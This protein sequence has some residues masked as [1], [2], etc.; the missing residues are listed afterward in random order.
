MIKNLLMLAALCVPSLSMAETLSLEM[1]IDQALQNSPAT[2]EIMQNMAEMEAA[3]LEASTL[4]N[5]SLV[6]D[7][8]AVKDE[9]ART[10]SLDLALP[11]KLS[12]F[13]AGQSYAKAMRRTATI[14]QQ[15]QMLELT[16]TMTRGYI[17]YWALQE[18]A[19]QLALNADYARE[20]QKLVQRAAKDGRVDISDAK[21]F[22][23]E[24]LRLEEQLR[25]IQAQVKKSAS[26]LLRLAGIEQMPFTA[27]KPV[28]T[29]LPDLA[30]LTANANHEGGIRSLLESRKALAEQR[31]NVARKDAGFSE[32]TPRAIIE[33]DLDADDTTVLL[34]VTIAIPIW[35]RNKAEIARARAEQRL[36]QSNLNALNEHNFV[37]LLATVYENAKATQTS[38]ETYSHKIL[39]AWQDV[40][41]LTDQ[42][43]QNGQASIL[44]LFQMRERFTGVHN[45]ALQ[46]HIN[47]LEA[48]IELE[49]LLGQPL[50]TLKD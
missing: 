31:Y 17:A 22:E 2:A 18:T 37:N 8:T 11:L 30:T 38:A 7:T 40:Q 44:D 26:N 3:A 36:A 34:G 13:G 43:F 9:A 10:L 16:H 27:E 42:K 19:E 48:R 12:N 5:P 45:E 47:A 28:H 50:T 29:S 41:K 39:P 20:K 15:A 6:I 35:D 49:S 32:F 24:A 1:M 21:I 25:V 46:T 23:A 33:R 14:E 4:E